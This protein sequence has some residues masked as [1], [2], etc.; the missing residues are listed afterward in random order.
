MTSPPLYHRRMASSVVYIDDDADCRSRTNT[1][2]PPIY[3][4]SLLAH[5]RTAIG[6]TGVL[7]RPTTWVQAGRSP[8]PHRDFH[9]AG[10]CH[11]AHP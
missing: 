4:S 9:F 11:Q 8:S 2:A 7:L 5:I 10:R 3:Q 1:Q 6:P